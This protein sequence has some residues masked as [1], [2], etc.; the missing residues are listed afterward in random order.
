MECLANVAQFEGKP[1]IVS[2]CGYT[3]EDGFEV[4]VID[5]DIEK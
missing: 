1:M 5:A 2:R 3:G 4:S